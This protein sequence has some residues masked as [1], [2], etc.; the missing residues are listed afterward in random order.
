MF[1]F[2]Q[3]DRLIESHELHVG[4][5]S[6]LFTFSARSL[7]L[8]PHPRRDPLLYRLFSRRRVVGINPA[9]RFLAMQ[10]MPGG[11]SANRGYYPFLVIFASVGTLC[12]AAEFLLLAKFLLSPAKLAA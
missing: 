10:A 9:S 12:F 4:Y 11:F 2:A 5:S 1:R 7:H 8:P 6:P 3:H